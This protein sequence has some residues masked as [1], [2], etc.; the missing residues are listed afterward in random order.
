[1]TGGVRIGANT[2]AS[3]RAAARAGVRS[4]NSTVDVVPS[5]PYQVT[6]TQRD[7]P[8]HSVEATLYD[9]PPTPT[10]GGG[11]WEEVPLPKRGAVLIWRGRGLMKLSF[12]VVFDA[13]ADESSVID[14]AY[15]TL[16]RFWRP[17]GGNTKHDY[18]T[19]EP[20]VLKLNAKGDV[21]PYRNL[22]WVI[23]SLEW[24]EGQGDE[25]GQ[26]TQQ[27]LVLTF[28]EYR[29]DERLKAAAAKRT[30]PYTWQK[31]DTLAKVAER[32]HTSAAALGALQKPPVSDGRHYK[33]GKTKIV[34]PA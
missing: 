19:D 14:G 4:G 27:V 25:D 21:I 15:T 10:E 1:M 13:F 16:L 26:R 20:S 8:H 30:K 11:G 31:G 7:T 17:E 23:S 29:A 22:A 33:A 24:G 34:V 6:I 3:K 28:T 2:L 18:A 9:R 32:H 12:S 5:S